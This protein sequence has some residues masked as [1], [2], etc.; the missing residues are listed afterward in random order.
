MDSPQNQLARRKFH[1][2]KWILAF[3]ILIVLN[4]FFFYGIRVVRPEP[5]YQ[6][7]CPV[8]QVT[9]QPQTQNECIAQGG[10]WTDYQRGEAPVKPD[11]YG[12]VP[13]KG[14][15]DLNYT[16]Q[17]KYDADHDVYLRD[18]FVA[19]V[20]LAVLAIVAAFFVSGAEAVSLGL[21]LGGVLSLFIA[22]V[23]YWSKLGQYLQV[24]VLGLALIAL[25]WLGI[26]KAKAD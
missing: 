5:D 19:R 13:A 6:V 9:V 1:P 11:M 2:M 20:I 21:S 8:Q 24:V 23:G 4:L 12:N 18:V 15:C 16:C 14:Y 17:K 7:Y 26:K 3:A 22:M 10:G 25:I